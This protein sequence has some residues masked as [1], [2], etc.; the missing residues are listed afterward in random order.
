MLYMFRFIRVHRLFC[1]D[2]APNGC[3]HV[4]GL[5]V[6]LKEALGSK[7]VVFWNFLARQIPKGYISCMDAL[8]RV[9]IQRMSSVVVS[10]RMR[11]DLQCSVGGVLLKRFVPVLAFYIQ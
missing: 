5:I 3:T 7:Q 11:Y 6:V 1:S 9:G 10:R 4:G 8:E 2:V